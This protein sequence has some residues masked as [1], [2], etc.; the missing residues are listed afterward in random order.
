MKATGHLYVSSTEHE[1]DLVTSDD[2]TASECGGYI[3]LRAKYLI[4]ESRLS[5]TSGLN[6]G[7]SF[8]KQHA[9]HCP[10]PD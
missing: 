10:M 2:S 6:K 9:N 1:I 8:G 3:P 7:D 5:W 4:V